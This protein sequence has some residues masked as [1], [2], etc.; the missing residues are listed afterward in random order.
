M[1]REIPLTDI[2]FIDIETI[3]AYPSFTEAPIQEQEFWKKKADTLNRNQ[4]YDVEEF[5]QRA[6]IYAEFGRVVC[7]STGRLRP[8]TA[9]NNLRL[10]I[11]SFIGAD[12]NRLLRELSKSLD[13]FNSRPQRLCA[14]NGKEFD[15]PY[16]SRRFLINRLEL[17]K[18][19]NN[20]GKKPW[21]I[22]HLDTLDIWK[23]G[24]YKHY[25]SLDRLASLFGIE[26]PKSEM[27]GS[28]VAKAW[29]QENLPDSIRKY[30]EADVL[31][32]VKV[33]LHIRDQS[34]TREISVEY[35]R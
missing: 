31:T 5:Y 14:H 15:F 25:T 33:F 28:M 19:L 11:R 9:K 3:P 10:E 8:L 32:L 21:E 29:Y 18:C 17:P 24:D 23:F 20:A 35:C 2:L 22:M 34:I 13:K 26:S 7:V 1:L 4:P 6:G 12:E 16:L 27:D 30:C